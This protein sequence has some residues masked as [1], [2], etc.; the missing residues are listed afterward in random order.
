MS[1]IQIIE[2]RTKNHEELQALGDEYFERTE[3]RRT[4]KRSRITYKSRP[5]GSGGVV[6]AAGPAGG[7]FDVDGC[8]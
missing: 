5:L 2:M 8:R 7:D 4:L 1:F 3:G 6:R